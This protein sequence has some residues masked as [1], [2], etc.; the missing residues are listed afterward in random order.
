MLQNNIT[1]KIIDF[2]AG[3]L[4]PGELTEFFQEIIDS[5]LIWELQGHY[6]RVAQDLI[7][8]GQCYV[9]H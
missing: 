7:D 2:E 3:E 8:G 9:K 6:Q 5:G 1:E 4:E